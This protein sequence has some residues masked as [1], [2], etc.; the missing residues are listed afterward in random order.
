MYKDSYSIRK[1][2]EVVAHS[3][4][5]L[6]HFFSD[7]FY[8]MSGFNLTYRLNACPS[9]ISGKDCSG[10][11]I[12]IDGICTCDGPWDGSACH[13]EKCP[14]SC[15]FSEGHG[16]CEPEVGC[17]CNRG[18]AGN[19]CGQEVEKGYWKT[20][21]PRNFIPPGSASHGAAVWKDSLYIVA[22]ESYYRG[23]MLYVYD[24]TGKKYFGK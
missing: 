20:V 22:G 1:I 11:G 15:G 19:D 10:N 17:K 24:F 4:A 14:N 7:D 13:I 18:Y 3:G 12:C 23:Q 2:P 16:R 6:V 21:T 8:N 5:A 9:K